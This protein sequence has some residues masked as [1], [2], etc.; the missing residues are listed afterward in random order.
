MEKPNEEFSPECIGEYYDCDEQTREVYCPFS[1]SCLALFE[2]KD[3]D[4]F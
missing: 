4:A 1:E 3:H 2:S